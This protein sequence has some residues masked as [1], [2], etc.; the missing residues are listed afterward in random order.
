M[1]TPPLLFF[2][3]GELTAK[4]IELYFEL[5]RLD[6]SLAGLELASWTDKGKPAGMRGRKAIGSQGLGPEG[7]R[8]VRTASCRSMG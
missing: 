5:D 7:G 2:E 4:S 3:G 8:E 6:C 1:G